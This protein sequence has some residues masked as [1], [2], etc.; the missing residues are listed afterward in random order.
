VF[1]APA[2]SRGL[3][4]I[5]V[6]SRGLRRQV[7][8][9]GDAVHSTSTRAA[10]EYAARQ[11][12]LRRSARHQGIHQRHLPP[13]KNGTERLQVVVPVDVPCRRR[14]AAS[15]AAEMALGYLAGE[16]DNDLQATR[17][18]IAITRINLDSG[19]C[20]PTAEL[21]LWRLPR[22]THPEERSR[23]LRFSVLSRA[24]VS[25]RHHCGWRWKQAFRVG[26]AT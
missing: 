17:A 20:G 8:T 1:G 19:P 12:G 10:V 24:K 3:E 7:D 2:A 11:A 13:E 5:P 4:Q 23:A 21:G 15:K 25:A 6:G 9:A 16:I 14:P 18:A 26:V 22:R